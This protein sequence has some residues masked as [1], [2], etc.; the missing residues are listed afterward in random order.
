[1]LYLSVFAMG[2][3]SALHYFNS[4]K[5]LRAAP[6]VPSAEL[7]KYDNCAGGCFKVTLLYFQAF[8]EH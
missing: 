2:L 7:K 8:R 6:S 4:S 3:K 1:V 5:K